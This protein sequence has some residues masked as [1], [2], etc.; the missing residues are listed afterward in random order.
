MT[1]RR[2]KAV[3][4]VLLAGVLWLAF[5]PR[6]P[7]A[8]DTGWDKLNHALAFC[9]LAVTGRFGFP[10][11]LREAMRL[12]LGLVVLGVAIEV[13]QSF[14]PTRSAEVNDVLADIVG[15]AGGLAAAAAVGRLGRPFT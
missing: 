11:R 4:T 3:F 12:A 14:L 6:P 2:W 9:A 8:L 13:V 10:G 7:H 15:I 1:S 5:T